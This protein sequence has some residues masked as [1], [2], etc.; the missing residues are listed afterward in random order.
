M[1]RGWGGGGHGKAPA[2][3]PAA[4]QRVAR[5][6]G[7]VNTYHL[8]ATLWRCFRNLRAF[9]APWRRAAAAARCPPHC[10]LPEESPSKNRPLRR[11]LV[12]IRKPERAIFPVV[13]SGHWS[14]NTVA[15]C[16]FFHLTCDF[17]PTSP[18]WPSRNPDSVPLRKNLIYLQNDTVFH[19]FQDSGA[20]PGICQIPGPFSTFRRASGKKKFKN[21][22]RRS[23]PQQLGTL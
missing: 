18:Q 23:C 16:H 15:T 2:R 12:A 20:P 7:G 8:S 11:D 1:C 9:G 3:G 10:V 6:I 13:L 19:C 17:Q 5:V 4:G 22:S 14:R 21:L